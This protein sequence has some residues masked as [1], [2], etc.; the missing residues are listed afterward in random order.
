M[1]GKHIPDK[2]LRPKHKSD[3]KMGKGLEY[4]S[5]EKINKW[6]KSTCKDA[7]HLFH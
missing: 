1:G 5:P 3:S 4:L 7:Q 2:G 6:S